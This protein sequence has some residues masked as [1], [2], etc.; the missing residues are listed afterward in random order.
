[1]EQLSMFDGKIFEEY[2]DAPD[3]FKKAD[4]LIDLFLQSPLNFKIPKEIPA[5]MVLKVKFRG[6]GFDDDFIDANIA[7][8]VISLQERFNEAFEENG[9]PK[10]WYLV[11]VKVEKGC[12]EIKAY[13]DDLIKFCKNMKSGHKV[14]VI[15]IIAIALSGSY[16]TH[17]YFDYVEKKVDAEIKKEE[18]KNAANR[19]ELLVETLRSFA[20]SIQEVKNSRSDME[21]PLRDLIKTAPKNADISLNS[22]PFVKRDDALEKIKSTRNPKSEFGNKYIDGKY[23]VLNID[24]AENEATI[25]IN[26]K[27]L[28]I[29]FADFSKKEKERLVLAWGKG[30]EMSEQELDLRITVDCNDYRIRSAK[31]IGIDAPRDESI[32]PDAIDFLK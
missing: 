29:S 25:L 22:A 4:E 23:R 24:D 8:Y 7:K 28:K 13:I 18:T 15:L 2:P 16:L 14:L 6:D 30:G 17:K 5:S 31:L 20:G 26:Q 9:L 10:N 3:F 1:M 11:K 32:N 12:K 27:E 21:K 19:D